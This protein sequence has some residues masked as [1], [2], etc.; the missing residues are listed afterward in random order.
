M[1]EAAVRKAGVAMMIAAGVLALAGCKS[2]SSGVFSR[3]RPNEFEVTRAAPLVVPPDYALVPPKPGVPR[4]QDADSSS[5]ALQAMF[6]GPAPRSTIESAMLNQAGAEDVRAGARS[7]TGSP[8][9]N[10]VNKG[11]VTRDI[12]AAPE[13][14]GQGATVSTGQ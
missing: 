4:P 13:G 14:Q 3:A 8:E 9:T 6:G 7:N 10:V 12:I 1:R 2:S 11:G 5:Q